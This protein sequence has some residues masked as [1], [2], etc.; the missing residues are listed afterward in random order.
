MFVSSPTFSAPDSPV[1]LSTAWYDVHHGLPDTSRVEAAQGVTDPYAPCYA[2]KPLQDVNCTSARE[3]YDISAN[4]QRLTNYPVPFYW[5]V[6]LGEVIAHPLR[7]SVTGDA[8]RAFGLLACL[9]LLFLAARRLHRAEERSAIWAIF[10]LFPP[11]APFLMAG[12]NP[13]GWEIACSV[14]F[15]ATL[16]AQRRT[17]LHNEVGPRQMLTIGIAALL[18]STARP[19]SGIWM[20][21]VTAGVVL[22]FQLWKN[23]RNLVRLAISILPGFILSVFW[24]VAFPV[25][26]KSISSTPLI[27]SPSVFYHHVVLSLED[28]SGKVIQIWGVLGWTDVVPSELVVIAGGMVLMYFLP[29]IAPTAKHRAFLVGSLGVVF[30]SSAL[31]EALSWDVYPQWW[32]GRYSITPLVGL[33]MV[34]FSGR[35]QRER[36]GLFALA[37]VAA[38]GDAYMVCLNFWRYSYGISNGFPAQLQHSAYVPAHALHVYA[39]VLVLLAASGVLFAAHFAQRAEARGVNPTLDLGMTDFVSSLSN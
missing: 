20:V 1:H 39:F 27:P 12:G 17:I 7:P 36:L 22:W 14:F 4:T 11:A 13:N 21:L 19:S 28:L 37:A 26:P 15:I 31:F 5:I 23:K 2:F 25:L 30:I 3:S 33:L 24:Q 10:L 35:D 16:L 9:A 34:L 8:G 29:T 32:Q 6:G 18:F 38:L